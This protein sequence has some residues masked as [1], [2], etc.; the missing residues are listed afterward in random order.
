MRTRIV[1]FSDTHECQPLESSRGLFDKRLFGT[2]NSRVFRKHRYHQAFLDLAVGRILD[3]N[4]DVI[5]FSGDA[6]TCGQPSEFNESKRR[7]KPLLDSHIPILYTPGNHDAYV[8]VKAN[9]HALEQFY[10]EL[11]RGKDLSDSSPVHCFVNGLE[12]YAVHC[13]KPTNPLSSGGV[14]PRKTAESLLASVSEKKHGPVI[15]CGHF[16]ELIKHPILQVRRRLWGGKAVASAICN[17]QIDLS[18]CGHVHK[19]YEVIDSRGR[20]EF[21]SGSLT[22]YGVLNVITYESEDDIFSFQR[23]YLKNS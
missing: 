12:F 6:T 1:H 21:C 3:L 14:M 16:P 23:I 18:L 17:G 5:V 19:P 15:L 4:P 10:T 2:L 22:L 9:R 11:T 20:G 8:N 13:A 7:L